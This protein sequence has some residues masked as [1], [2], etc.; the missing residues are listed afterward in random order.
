M[1]PMLVNGMI[2]YGAIGK[3]G[4]CNTGLKRPS[5][6]LK[7]TFKQPKRKQGQD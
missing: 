5:F 2:E 4:R 1:R 7:V 3:H 6:W